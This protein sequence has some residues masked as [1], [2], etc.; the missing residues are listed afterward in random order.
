MALTHKEL[1][2]DPDRHI[3]RR[4][5]LE[6]DNFRCSLCGDDRT[7]MQILTKDHPGEILPSGY[8]DESLIT[9]CDCCAA[10]AKANK[11]IH[12]FNIQEIKAVYMRMPNSQM[13]VRMYRL[14]GTILLYLFNQDSKIVTAYDMSGTAKELCEFLK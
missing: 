2:K 8:P 12:G 13:S 7:S 4:R 6:R 5:I 1:T 11:K 9:L 10:F 14:D 3:T